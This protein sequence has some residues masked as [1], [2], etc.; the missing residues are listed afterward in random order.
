[1]A[2]TFNVLIADP[3]H[4]DGHKALANKPNIRVDV[5]TGLDEAGLIAKVPGYDA[6]IVRSKSRV[7][8]PVIAAGNALKV[9]GRAGIGVDNIDVAAA[10]ERGIVVFNTPD[11]N[12]TTTAELTLAHLMSL[13]R[14]LPRA[15]RSVRNKEWQPQRFV[16]TEIAGKIVGIIG[17]GTIGRLVAERCAALKMKV[18][19]F[20]PFVTKEIMQQ[21]AAE[22][23]MLDDLLAKSDYVTLH[24][25]LTDK[26]R[27][28]IDEAR[29]AAMKPGA[30]IINCARGGLVDETA[31]LEALNSGHLAGAALDVFVKEPPV[32][33]PLLQLDNVVLT[34]H[35]GAS[36]EE[37]QQAVSV[38]IA[39]VIAKFLTT[40]EAE[41]AVNLPRISS[42]QFG[43][44]KPYQ[45][46]AHSLGRLVGALSGGP[47]T[48]L[49]VRLFGRVSE[50]DSRPISAGAIV[51]LLEGWLPDRVNRVNAAHLAKAHGI[52]TRVSQSEFSRD[53]LSLI[54]V[55][56]VSDGKT[57]SVAGTLLG[58]RLPR[59]VRIDD[60]PVEAV[61]E[62]HFL[63]THHH[64]RP[65]VVGALGGILGRE[66]INIQRMHVGSDG[67]ASAAIAL[68]SIS[69]PLSELIRKEIR[70]LPQIIDA[71]DFTL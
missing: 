45:V 68:I 24:C 55:S 67:G 50:L 40:G 18:L 6:L 52:E 48:E 60:Y 30:R 46:L 13:S 49:V 32:E 31:L 20:D 56:A 33:S 41:A 63:F 44:S 54:E 58:G 36:T 42:E 22:P 66:N 62:G 64:D 37:A 69:A 39:E 61:P 1:M 71:V 16:G 34:P 4:E 7:T 25:P 8:R 12:A 21:F 23:Q 9:V 26:T 29:I 17:F 14:H 5:V 57:T 19:A 3:V 59:L 28:L 11:A 2:D 35:L 43:L 38:K 51:G 53:Y 10:T 47:I 65:G 70:E 27:N 15:D